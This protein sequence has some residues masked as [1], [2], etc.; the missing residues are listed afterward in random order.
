MTARTADKIFHDLDTCLDEEQKA[1]LDGN[2]DRIDGLMEEKSAL[3]SELNSLGAA[4]KPGLDKLRDK[5]Q[6]N[7]V[8]LDGALEGIRLVSQRIADLQAL[9]HS[10]ETYDARGQ[11]R[12]IEG[13][14]V[15]KVEKRS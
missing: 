12:T 4:Q 8:L 9:R 1:L 15:R 2:L 6:R 14:I 13:K 3:I 7:Q 11:R 10:F 5:A